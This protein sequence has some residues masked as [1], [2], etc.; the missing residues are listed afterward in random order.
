LYITTTQTEPNA[1]RHEMEKRLNQR[2]EGYLIEFKNQ[3]AGRIQNIVQDIE[4]SG[5]LSSRD[6]SILGETKTKCNSLAAFVYN[7][8]KI[9]VGKDDFMKRKRVKSV[10]PIYDRCCAKRASGEQCTRRKKEGESYCGTHIKGTPHS[11]M[12]EENLSEPSTPKNV[13]VDIWAQDIRGII[14]Y[15]DKTGNVYDTE[16]IMKIDKYPKRVIAKYVQDAKGGYSIP[17]IFGGGGAAV[18]L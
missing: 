12:E 6:I 4:E 16:D 18:A 8:E 7:Y 13:K 9:K 11:V 3:V 14:Y 10:V 15:I 2:I 5:S 17:S 1:R